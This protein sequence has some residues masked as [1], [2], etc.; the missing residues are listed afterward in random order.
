MSTHVNYCM[1]ADT[2]PHECILSCFSNKLSTLIFKYI[3]EDRNVQ[4]A[5]T[6]KF[7]GVKVGLFTIEKIIDRKQWKCGIAVQSPE[8]VGLKRKL[9]RML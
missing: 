5:F 7:P 8:P 4:L 1:F 6:H 3:I 9:M 2:C